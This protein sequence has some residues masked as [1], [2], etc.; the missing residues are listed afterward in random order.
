MIE[1]FTERA[2]RAVILATEEARRRRH[3]AVGAEHLLMGILRDA[4]PL[5][6]KWLEHLRVSPETLSAEIERVLS[7][8]AA[9]A[10]SGEPAFSP[11]LKAMLETTLLEQQRHSATFIG[12]E[13]LLLGLL[14]DGRS[15]ASRILS[16]AGADLDKARLLVRLPFNTPLTEDKVRFIATSMWRVQISGSR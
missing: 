5:G 4:G 14:A 12:T 2:R 3:A 9:S 13:H 10:T 16:A 1:R 15:M 7:Q 6:L 11:E 8:A